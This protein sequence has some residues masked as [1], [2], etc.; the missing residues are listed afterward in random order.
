MTTVNTILRID[1]SARH[2]GSVTRDLTD[3]LIDHLATLSPIQVTDRDVSTG[4]PFV[5]QD[6]VN[7]NFTPEDDRTP[8]QVAKLTLSA[9]LVEELKDAD[10]LVIGVPIYN[11]GIPATLKAWVDMVCRARLTFRYTENGPVGLLEGK[12]AYLLVASGGT[13]IESE[14]DFATPYMRQ[15]LAF[16]GIEDVTVIGAEKM[17]ANADNKSAALKTIQSITA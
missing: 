3:Q 2:A 1:S 4:L 6:W 9:S 16:V 12:R 14:M 7:A 15:M 11:F 10:I 8:D 17:M 5:D 13:A